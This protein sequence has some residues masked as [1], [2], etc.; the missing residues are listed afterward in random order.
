M[1]YTTIVYFYEEIA[2][3]V[4][5][6]V[7]LCNIIRPAQ[8]RARSHSQRS[9]RLQLRRS[10]LFCAGALSLL[11]RATLYPFRSEWFVL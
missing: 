1:Q 3:F 9:H 6:I 7:S 10:H 2:A 4:T 8:I 5:R 11:V